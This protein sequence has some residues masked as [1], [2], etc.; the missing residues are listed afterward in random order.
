MPVLTA[1]SENSLPA[2]PFEIAPL[3]APAIAAQDRAQVLA[4]QR[5]TGALLRAVT[6]TQRAAADAMTQ[7]Q[8][9]QRALDQ[10]PAAG[11]ALR[12]EARSLEIRMMDLQETLNGSRTLSSRSEPDMP[13]IVG[14]VNGVVFGHWG[15]LH[16]PTQTHRQQY[17][18]AAGAFG[19]VH[20]GLTQLIETDLPALEARLEAA[21]VPWTTGRSLPRW[22]PNE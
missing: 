18:I 14:R 16:G 10:N 15:T 22:P 6:G 11:D 21:G 20:A 19:A 7:I 8:T 2:T 12:A 5:Q 17:Q 3:Y 9:I 4:F 13:G 1:R